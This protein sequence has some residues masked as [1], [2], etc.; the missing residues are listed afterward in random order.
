[1]KKKHVNEVYNTEFDGICLQDGWYWPLKDSKCW[2][3]LINEKDMPEKVS[4][5]CD[6][7]RTIIEAGGNAGYYV[8]QYASIF[9]NVIT[10]EPEPLNFQCLTL[11]CT[12]A[13][14]TKIQACIGNERTPVSLWVGNKNIGSYHVDLTVNGKIPTL[15]IDDLNV[16][17][18]DLIHLDIEGFEFPALRGA[19]ET[20]KRCKP[21]IAVESMN[22]GEK[23]GWSNLMIEDFLKD[24]NYKHIDTVY[25]DKIFIY[26]K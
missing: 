20:I 12:L 17:D 24:L 10:F 3:W 19:I 2:P 4:A 21:V 18:C 16:Q 25:H 15:L 7:K 1:M 23:F 5:F 13:N 26:S 8:K 9:E 11:N 6:Q 22:H 14:V